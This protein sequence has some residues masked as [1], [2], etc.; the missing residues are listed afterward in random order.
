MEESAE[1]DLSNSDTE[2]E[3][4]IFEMKKENSGFYQI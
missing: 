2:P 4:F 3:D 1:A